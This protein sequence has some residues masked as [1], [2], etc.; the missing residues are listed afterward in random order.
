MVA[1]SAASGGAPPDCPP[2]AAAAAPPGSTA[3]ASAG[4]PLAS[5]PLR[6]PPPPYPSEA[7]CPAA[8]GARLLLPRAF[9][10]GRRTGPRCRSDV[11]PHIRAICAICAVCREHCS[12]QDALRPSPEGKR[13]T[14][15]CKN[16]ALAPKQK[17]ERVWCANGAPRRHH[18][19]AAAHRAPMAPHSP[20]RPRLPHTPLRPPGTAPKAQP[21]GWPALAHHAHAADAPVQATSSPPPRSSSIAT[22]AHLPGRDERDARGR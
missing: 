15:S 19:R 8:A 13:E 9:F 17:S 3:L 12:A 10:R 11:S 21:T 6:L 5:P 20:A 4:G 22:L 1:L 2:A 16:F 7:A 18:A 14:V